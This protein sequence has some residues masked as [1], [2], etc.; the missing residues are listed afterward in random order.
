MTDKEYRICGRCIMDTS[1]Y[2]ITFD[3]NGECNFCKLHDKL[4]AEFPLGAEGDRRLS[5]LMAKIRKAGKGNKYDCIVGVSGGRD[6]TYLLYCAVKKFGLRPLAVHFND[7]FD[8]PVCGKN[9]KAAVER[10]GVDLRTIT[11]DW[12]ESKAIRLALLR[13]SVTSLEVGTDL[14]II[15][16]LYGV[17]ARENIAYIINGM[18]FRSEGLSPLTWNYTDGRYLKSVLKQF[19]A[20]QIR[21]WTP[22][23]PGFTL[24]PSTVF[25]YSVLR[26]IKFVTPYYHYRYRLDE[27][28]PVITGKLGWEAP[29]AKYFDDLYQSLI[30]YVNRVKFGIDKRRMTYSALIRSGQ[31][32]RATAVEEMKRPSEVEDPKVIDL[33]IKRL[34]MTREEFDG[35]MALPPRIFLDYPNNYWIFRLLKG[36]IYL[37]CRM[38]LLPAIAYDKYF[39]CGI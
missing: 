2:G 33:C 22:T 3:E 9:I 36:P 11:S 37:A 8:N 25:Y 4:D 39:N 1:V 6:S 7:G 24:L 27:I 15:N 16:A 20:G 32:E 17:A 19:G 31:M 21:K 13:A 23:D 14:G 18:D 5:E 35:I 28:E 29:G 38:G 34:G 10:L 26:G 30:Y 12:R